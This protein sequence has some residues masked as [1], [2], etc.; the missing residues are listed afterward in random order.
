MRNRV[1]QPD[2]IVGETRAYAGDAGRQ[3]RRW[4]PPML[5]VTLD[6]LAACCAQQMLAR[7]SRQRQR[8]RHSVLQLIAKAVGAAGLIEGGSR[9]H[10]A[11][12]RLIERP[13]IEHE[14]E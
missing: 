2:P 14:V 13:S 8:Q 7:E 9:P 3:I 5:H 4:Q 11:Y 12:Q 1:L 10:P 6:E